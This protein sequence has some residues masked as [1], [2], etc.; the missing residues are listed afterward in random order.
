MTAVAS[1]SKNKQL[2][3][4]PPDGGWG[5]VVVLGSFFVHVFA[6]GFVYSFGVLVEVLMKEFNSDNT[7][8][9]MIISL[10]TG[11]T[12]GSGPLASAI[13][14]KYGCRATTITGALI[15]AVGCGISYFA[16]EMWQIVFSVGVI[17]GVGF[18]LMYCPAI[19]I[20][21]MYF[22][23]RRSLATGIAV[24]GAGVGTVLF[25]PI[26]EY[27]ISH[28]GWRAV[29]LAFEGVLG[30]CV[31]CGWTFRPLHFREVSEEEEEEAEDSIEMKK[32]KEATIEENAALL[33]T[34]NSLTVP[35]LPREAKSLED[36][37]CSEE[38]RAW[39]KRSDTV[40]ERHAG[41]I[42][43][44]DVFYTG[45]ITNVAEFKE[46]PHKYRST[47]SLQ[48]RPL[49]GTLSVSVEKLR[50]VRE[51]SEEVSEDTTTD[52]VEGSHMF[53]TISRMLSLSLLL[54]P[55]FL[56]FAISNLLTSVGFNSPLYFLPLHAMKGVGLDSAS[57]SRVLSV[58]GLCNT[59]GRVVF[60][61]VADHRLPLPY[62]L[63]ED[64]ARNRLWMYNI[65]L[66]ICGILTS[67]CYLFTSFVS[68][69]VYAG[70]FGFSISSYICLT[71]VILVDLLGL[72]KLTNAFGLLL[73]WQG[74]GTV[75]GPP[76]SGYLADITHSYVW[77]FVFC[78]ANLLI[79]GLMLF[80]IPYFQKKHAKAQALAKDSQGQ[81]K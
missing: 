25:S 13:C 12:L 67:F 50:E 17:M 54:D 4:I 40:G 55:T 15:A 26:N 81:A 10:L 11:L 28:Y 19:V 16:T 43:R 45:S 5:W 61:V 35:K 73:L 8:C 49:S 77:S 70:L 74:V 37:S 1:P 18:G 30:L 7:V 76:I 68:L 32:P 3:P 34:G 64:V 44:K 33:T 2:V 41:Y 23:K 47:G 71:S 9:A 62:G 75:F 38:E 36:I 29:F 14:N 51:T 53:K 69:S 20:V 66:S 79:S 21:T 57:S 56:I 24:A 63:G 59:L 31:I 39:R 48:R 58:F 42:N 46:H 60:G 52:N 27:I 65:S 22:E 80:T 6:D 72:D 78:G